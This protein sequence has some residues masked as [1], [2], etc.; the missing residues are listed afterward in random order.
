MKEILLT[1]VVTWG[2]KSVADIAVKLS[3]RT[4]NTTDDIIANNFK[5]IVNGFN[6]KR[7]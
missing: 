4:E 6:F 3:K 7:K 2:L 1:F 5:K